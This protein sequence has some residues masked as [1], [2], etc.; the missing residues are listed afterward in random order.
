VSLPNSEAFLKLTRASREILSE[1]LIEHLPINIFLIDKEGYICWVNERLL[2]LVNLSLEEAQ[3]IHISRW[4][5]VRWEYIYEVIMNQQET[6]REEI[7][8]NDYFSTI[9]RPLFDEN[10]DVMG[11]LGVSIEITDRKKSEIAK[12]HFLRNIRHDIRTPVS[13]IIGL[14]SVLRDILNE[15]E[16][17]ELL[18]ALTETSESLLHLLDRVFESVQFSTGE[19]SILSRQFSLKDTLEM[20]FKLHQAKAIEKHLTLLF[21]YD[22]ALPVIVVGEAMRVQRLVWELL[23]NALKYTEKGSI[24]LNARLLKQTSNQVMVEIQVKDTGIGIPLDK[25]E[26]VFEQ[27]TRLTSAWTGGVLGQGLGL[28][29]VKQLIADLGGEISLKSAIDKGSTFTCRISFQH[30]YPPMGEIDFPAR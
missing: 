25:H 7:Y 18:D 8:G 6:T 3:G 29:N 10:G 9:R 21:Y 13:G 17:L 1:C 19:I 14:A 15:S 27:F 4:G 28:F 23:T 11:V 16:P 5:G 24:E 30:A 20:V 2:K 12:E 22:P 26:M